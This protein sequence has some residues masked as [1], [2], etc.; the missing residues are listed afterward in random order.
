MNIRDATRSLS[1]V[2]LFVAALLITSTFL[3]APASAV[4]L[5]NEALSIMP[6]ELYQPMKP[7]QAPEIYGPTPANAQLGNQGLS[8]Q[9]RKT[10]TVSVF[11]WPRP[12]MY[13]QVKMHTSSREDGRLWGAS[14][15]AGQFFGLVVVDQY[16]T[17]EKICT[18]YYFNLFGN[19]ICKPDGWDT[20]LTD[21]ADTTTTFLRSDEWEVTS[22]EFNNPLNDVVI[23]EY[24]SDKYDLDVTV[25]DLVPINK[26]VTADEKGTPGSYYDSHSWLDE[27]QEVLDGSALIRRVTISGNNDETAQDGEA[28]KVKLF[29]FS[30]FNMTKNHHPYI[31]T[32]DW[33]EAITKM[34]D[35]YYEGK[36]T[37]EKKGEDAVYHMDQDRKNA[38]N[39]IAMGFG[40]QD[41]DHET[42]V[43]YDS[44]LCTSV[45]WDC[46]ANFLIDGSASLIGQDLNGAH[47]YFTEKNNSRGLKS[48]W[49]N[50]GS[51][52]PT[53]LGGFGW[54]PTLRGFFTSTGIQSE[55]LNPA[56]G[57]T[58]NV[59]IVASDKDL[60]ETQQLLASA[61]NMAENNW[62]DA[63]DAKG[64]WYRDV[65]SEAPVPDA[66]DQKVVDLSKRALVTLVQNYDPK[67]G[68][69]VDGGGAIVASVARQSPYGEDWPR[70]G[71]YFNYVLD[72]QLKLHDWVERRNKWYA[73]LQQKPDKKFPDD[74]PNQPLVPAGN[75]AMN[76]YGNGV[77]GGI[78]PWEIDETG[79]MVAAFWDHY[80]ATD[81]RSYLRDIY[82]AIKR[83][84]DFLVQFKDPDNNLQKKAHEDD[85]MNK[86]QTMVGA[87]STWMGLRTAEKAAE[88]LGNMN[89]AE[90]YRKRRKELG[91]AINTQLWNKDR[92]A[93]GKAHVG[94]AEIVWPV[95][96]RDYNNQRVRNH[97]ETSWEKIEPTFQTF[98]NPSSAPDHMKNSQG[99]VTG[100][101]E[102]KF[103]IALAKAGMKKPD[104]QN[105]LEL[106]ADKW[107]T[108]GTHL[109]GEVWMK[110][111]DKP[112][113]FGNGDQIVT[114]VSQPHA[115]EQCLFYLAAINS[116]DKKDL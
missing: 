98:E 97:L 65:L 32:S 13:D 71:F 60:D 68:P 10:G 8:V 15:N 2:V 84:A 91:K 55:L 50:H 38:E 102:T 104:V 12:S 16:Q 63:V 77:E 7:K 47:N 62:G 18:D 44:I 9:L 51:D 70:D 5:K 74:F 66:A 30:N 6:K 110:G 88:E 45:S 57:V 89:D 95:K 14:E 20:K 85:H 48:E 59:V 78:I 101:Y 73:D 67:G 53:S 35:A 19:K 36:S 25:K 61:R 33:A 115:W 99:V 93:W 31:P 111:D 79:Y 108:E 96:F 24:H 56:G 105:S 83:S 112:F 80:K 40:T 27:G 69:N 86:S 41:E 4:N 107:G 22:Q 42:Q 100:L 26:N 76:Y 37:P 54:C 11:A 58:E 116:Y 46:A 21:H 75:W 113:S 17:K 114:T 92:K 52:C 34:E 94:I 28:D 106:I 82:P 81:D 49:T 87:Q 39:I 64:D 90:R 23:T 103:L 72:H 29:S 43:G 109:M 1:T 3:A